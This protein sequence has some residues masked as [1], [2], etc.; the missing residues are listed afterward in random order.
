[1]NIVNIFNPTKNFNLKN[2]ININ[3]LFRDIDAFII[4]TRKEEINFCRDYIFP[5]NPNLFQKNMYLV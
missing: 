3:A 4:L 2:V 5:K 1:M